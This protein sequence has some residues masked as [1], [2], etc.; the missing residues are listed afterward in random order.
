MAVDHFLASHFTEFNKPILRFF[1]WQ[2]KAVSLGFHQK[3]SDVNTAKIKQDGLDLVRRPTGGRAIY[4]AN[5]L[6]YSIIYPLHG[7]N[8]FEL[9][10]SVHRAIERAG[11]AYAAVSLEE[12][13]A[14]LRGFY[15]QA[16]SVSCFAVSARS[17]VKSGDKKLVGSAQRLYPDAILQHGSIMLGAEHLKLVDYLNIEP[18]HREEFKARL[19]QKTT[20]L[21]LNAANSSR[22]QFIREIRKNLETIFKVKSFQELS[23]DRFNITYD[24]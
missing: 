24:I 9:Y 21:D 2:P 12:K 15:K 10:K 7:Q 14:D 19:R 17:E 8:K 3:E 4:H 22:A 11:A 23:L 13:E 1:D 6:T 5:E 16:D 18:Y 20:F